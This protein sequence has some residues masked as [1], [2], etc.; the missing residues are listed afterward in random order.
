MAEVFIARMESADATREVR[1]AVEHREAGL[2][3]GAWLPS[4]GGRSLELG[5]WLGRPFWGAG[6]MTEALTAVLG[7]VAGGWGKRALSSGH[8]A[9]NAASGRVLVKAGFLYTGE[10]ESALLGRP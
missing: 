3:R 10:V 6:L 8:F 7:W 9:D 4:Q 5:Y 2:H 1:L